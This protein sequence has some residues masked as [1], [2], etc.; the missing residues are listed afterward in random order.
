MQGFDFG[1]ANLGWTLISGIRASC[2][3]TPDP[4]QQMESWGWG[5]VID[6]GL[7]I[8]S[9]WFARDVNATPPKTPNSKG[10]LRIRAENFGLVAQ[11]SDLLRTYTPGS[12]LRSWFFWGLNRP[13]QITE[14]EHALQSTTIARNAHV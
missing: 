11:T 10:F 5:L 2:T 4:K 8:E 12:K 13:V 9:R 3:S 7:V 1:V 6:W 14:L